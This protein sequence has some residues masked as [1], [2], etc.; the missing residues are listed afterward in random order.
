MRTNT[1]QVPSTVFAAVEA[2]YFKKA[3]ALE[4]EGWFKI[5]ADCRA[6]FVK[7]NGAP[8]AAAYAKAAAAVA[9]TWTEGT[10][11][12][13]LLAVLK[14]QDLGFT[15][16]DFHHMTQVRETARINGSSAEK[17]EKVVEVEKPRRLSADQRMAAKSI[18]VQAGALGEDVQAAIAAT[19]ASLGIEVG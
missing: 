13:Y 9:D 19:L 1:T 3:D 12:V 15:M 16:A 17:V 7:K 10:I 8:N 18:V 4:L 14:V 11:R 2:K 5:A 6:N